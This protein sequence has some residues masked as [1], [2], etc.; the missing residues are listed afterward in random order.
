LPDACRPS[1]TS[2]S[3]VRAS[4]TNTTRATPNAPRYQV[5]RGASA[6]CES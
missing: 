1:A 6:Y 3:G 5:A 2:G 4:A